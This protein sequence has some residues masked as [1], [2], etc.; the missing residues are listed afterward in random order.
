MATKMWHK[1]NP[2]IKVKKQKKIE[3]LEK[4]ARLKWI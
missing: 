4:K 3:A 2:K 1:F